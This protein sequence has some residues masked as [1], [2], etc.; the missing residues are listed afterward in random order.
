MPR[1]AVLNVAARLIA[2]IPL[3]SHNYIYF[4]QPM[5]LFCHE[6]FM[7]EKLHWLPFSARIHFKIIF[8]VYKLSLSGLGS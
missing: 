1:E 2:R 3:F 6:T 5:E 4:H 7:T 8:L